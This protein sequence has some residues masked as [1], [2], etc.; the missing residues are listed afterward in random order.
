MLRNRLFVAMSFMA[1]LMAGALH[2]DK[3]A[4][5]SKAEVKHEDSVTIT[6]WSASKVTFKKGDA[7]VSVDYKDVISLD[8]HYGT[9]SGALSDALEL[10]GSDP[11]GAID[12]LE[13]V[14]QSGE[15]LDKEE[16]SIIRAQLL[17][18]ESA[19]DSRV[20]PAAIKAY[21]TYLS[22]WK[23]GYFAREAYRGLAALQENGNQD[24]AART[25][26]KNMI[27]AD[28]SMQREGNQLLG[29]FEARKA[30]WSD[31]I[32]A[33]K[34]AQ[35]A[36]KTDRDPN[37]EAL[38]KAWEGWMTLKAGNAAGAK[39]LLES[40]TT[41]DKLDDSDTTTDE[42]A[43]S[44]AFPALGDAHMDAG[45]YQKAYDAYVK[46]AYY[47]WW[48]AG[49]QEGRCLGQAYVCAKKLEGTDDKWKTRKDKLRTA[50]ALG[51]PRIL[52]DVEK[53]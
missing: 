46:G 22:N 16:A 7:T 25:T 30:K 6:D 11:Q 10:V 35:S 42:V 12:A 48:S 21:S 37:N 32:T 34:N 23:S 26:L 53:D 17:D 3:I 13:Q 39:T 27:K 47:A 50:L 40:V 9:M 20:A 4:Y 31:A 44:I 28:S 1:V 18:N 8:R 41:D 52:Q 51:F 14:A 33:F 15:S 5:I 43:L 36:A 38:A 24:G 29:E 2:A 45:N 49:S 19:A